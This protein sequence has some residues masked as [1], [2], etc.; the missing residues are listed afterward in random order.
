M[1][2]PALAGRRCST[3]ILA[4][5]ERR[6]SWPGGSSAR[7]RASPG[8]S[9][10]AT[11]GPRKSDRQLQASSGLIYDV[12]ASTTPQPAAR[13]GRARGARA[14]ARAPP[15]GELPAGRRGRH[16]PGD[17]A[18]EP[19]PLAFPI[20]VSRMRARVSSET[21]A[22]RVRRMQVRLE[23]A[24]DRPHGAAR[25]RAGRH[26]ERPH[27][28]RRGAV[29]PAPSR[30]RPLLETQQAARHRGR[31]LRQGRVVP[32]PR[33]PHPAGHP[34]DDLRRLDAVIERV[35]PRTLMVLGD[36][37]HAPPAA[38]PR[39]GRPVACLAPRPAGARVGP[40]VRQPRPPGGGRSSPR[41]ASTG[42][43]IAWSAR[44]PSSSTRRRPRPTVHVSGHVHPAVRLRGPARTC[45][46]APCFWIRP[47]RAVLPAF[48]GFT[49]CSRVRPRTGDRLFVIAAG[50]VV[51]AA[52]A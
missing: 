7:S 39:A 2:A 23:S 22:E 12:F 52:G 18:G 47:D 43:P 30:A 48:G 17:R 25:T 46:D 31:A 29:L 33:H 10:P 28:P 4:E 15:P 19:T 3:D 27:D 50:E 45:E 11:P 37:F 36:L 16:D 13:A 8:S 51:E 6:P 35:R 24:A 21:L 5:P 44:G 32:P 34:A 26:R 9:S 38:I 40:R 49:G 1:R 41:S 14:P 42:N 20:L